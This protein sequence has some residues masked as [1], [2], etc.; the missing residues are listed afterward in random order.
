M[1]MLA[2]GSL[3]GAR[4]AMFW[5]AMLGSTSGI[6]RESDPVSDADYPPAI[7]ELQFAIEGDRVSG[8]SYLAN[9]KGPH[10]TLV[11]VHGFP[12]NE[13]NLDIA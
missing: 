12:G 6:A 11:L 7:E 9:G 10:P 3:W 1:I 5:I 8:I 2:R 13:K 4:L